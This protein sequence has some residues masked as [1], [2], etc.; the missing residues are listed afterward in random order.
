[1]MTVWAGF[2]QNAPKKSAEERTEK[3]I[4]NLNKEVTLTADQ[5]TKIQAIQ[6]ENTKKVDEIRAKGMDGNKKAMRQDVKATNESTDSQIKALLTDE[7]KTKF[8]VWQERKKEEMKIRQA[9]GNGK[10]KQ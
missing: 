1:M 6:L 7:Q 5:S 4:K 3:F 10:E 8:D 9:G 2:A